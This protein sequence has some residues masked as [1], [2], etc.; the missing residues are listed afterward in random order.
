M[1]NPGHIEDTYEVESSRETLRSKY[2]PRNCESVAPDKKEELASLIDT[3]FITYPPICRIRRIHDLG[4][5][6]MKLAP[7]PY[8]L[9][10]RLEVTF[11]ESEG[12]TVKGAFQI[13]S[14]PIH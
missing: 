5:R 9:P 2:L 3:M 12:H 4:F 10:P 7:S 6:P 1:I 14:D 11:L 8:P 13:M